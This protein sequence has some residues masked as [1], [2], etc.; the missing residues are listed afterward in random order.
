M[1]PPK[2]S[3]PHKAHPHLAFMKQ[4]GPPTSL[5]S[6][7]L[8]RSGVR[9][10]SRFAAYLLG[11][12]VFV[13]IL[14]SGSNRFIHFRDDEC[15]HGESDETSTGFTIHGEECLSLA[16][17]LPVAITPAP[18]SCMPLSSEASGWIVAANTHAEPKNTRIFLPWS[19]PRLVP[20]TLRF[21]HKLS[22]SLLI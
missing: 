16:V 2:N 7:R 3:P 18:A 9:K 11:I 20:P 14:S 1:T 6:R 13:Q 5:L 22:T 21:R 4:I 10:L 17:T 15:H 8:R 12:L 19:D